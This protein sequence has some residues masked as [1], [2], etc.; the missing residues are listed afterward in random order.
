LVAILLLSGAGAQFGRRAQAEAP[1]RVPPETFLK[2]APDVS[3]KAHDL[4]F[5][6]S[7]RDDRTDTGKL[8]YSHRLLPL[9]EQW[10][11]YSSQTVCEYFN[12]KNGRYRFQVRAK[13]E[14]DNVDPAPAERAVL[15]TDDESLATNIKSRKIDANSLLSES[16]ATP[17]Y[18]KL[19]FSY[20]LLPKENAWSEFSSNNRKEYKQLPSGHYILLARA[21][22]WKGGKEFV[23][24]SGDEY[25]F[26]IRVEEEPEAR[27]LSHI[28]HSVSFNKITIEFTGLDNKTP[29][30]RLRYL[31]R[32]LPRDRNWTGPTSDRSV[33]LSELAR[34]DYTF[35]VKALDEAGHQS[36]D[37]ARVSFYV[38]QR[39]EPETYITNKDDFISALSKDSVTFWFTGYDN[40]TLVSELLYSWRL[41]PAQKEWSEFA[42]QTIATFKN[43]PNGDYTFQVRAQDREGNI[44]PTPATVPFRIGVSEEPSV[45]LK[46]SKHSQRISST[47]TEFEFTGHDNKTPAEELLY[48]YRLLPVEKNWS[49]FAKRTRTQY[50]NLS[51][52]HYYT[53]EVRAKD[54]DGNVSQTAS[55]QF[56]VKPF[57][58]TAIFYWMAALLVGL[59]LASSYSVVKQIRDGRAGRRPF[60][61]YIVG[62]PVQES[63]MFFGR[64][65]Y[66]DDVLN[67]LPDKSILIRGQRSIGKTSLQYELKKRLIAQEND[68]YQFFPA[69]ISLQGIEEERFFYALMA[70]IL[71]ECVWSSVHGAELVFK[72]GQAS[73]YAPEHFHSDLGKVVEILE[74]IARPKEPRLVLLI[75]DADAMN[76]YGE[77][78]HQAFRSLLLETFTHRLSAVLSGVSFEKHEDGTTG[79]WRDRF[80]MLELK[81]FSSQEAED[82]IRTPVRKKFAYEEM[83]LKYIIIYSERK[84]ALI[85]KIC[86]RALARA[87]ADHR[88]L[89]AI[90]DVKAACSE[91]H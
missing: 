4:R 26:D 41:L 11:A 75:D 39:E 46:T 20:R 88:I 30:D 34:G 72:D 79:P 70:S 21:R 1:D 61:P 37:P 43:L 22:G 49:L 66:L 89:I 71:K 52:D 91:L 25:A 2:N 29:V 10:S 14:Q 35:E 82:L 9:E 31:Y 77:A 24:Q 59:V 74:S 56:Y 53:F 28:P 12:V 15:V 3:V 60:N 85:Q 6:F 33:V 55:F 36:K 57:S 40:R 38:L 27:I 73:L 7:G 64:E 58:Q 16:S 76:H 65:K 32:L 13:D 67:S 80:I 19:A 51:R 69:Y 48:S 44:D 90:E 84:P 23:D 78:T 68:R 50:K 62:R 81:P 83:A 54:S 17:G 42:N 45:T 87:A 47:D 8:E 18:E 63:A 5:E 86:A